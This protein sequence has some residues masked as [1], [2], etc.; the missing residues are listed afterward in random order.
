[1]QIYNKTFAWVYNVL[2]K[3]FVE[4][5][6]PIILDFFLK[7]KA[8]NLDKSLLDVCCGTGQLIN[9]FCRNGFSST[10]IDISPAM[11]FFARDNN[12]NY[13]EQTEFINADAIN[14][15]LKKIYSLIV[16]TF[17]SLNH[18]D[19]LTELE[20]CF[21]G[22]YKSLKEEGY[23]IFDLNTYK[24]LKTWNGLKVEE[25]SELTIINHGVFI[26]EVSR[27]YTRIP[28]SPSAPACA[29][30]LNRPQ[31]MIFP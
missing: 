24:G 5:Q 13:P 31:T 14:F 11:L 21:T 18:F 30:P 3:D 22:V 16:S 1:M 6:A 15:D 8:Q 9:L 29:V 17:D 7:N 2:W 27:A 25:K 20:S 4:Y 19:N 23:F 26:E 12:K 10:G 28:S